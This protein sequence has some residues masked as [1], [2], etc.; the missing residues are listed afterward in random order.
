VWTPALRDLADPASSWGYDFIDFCLVIGWPLD[1][2]QRWLAI[3]LGELFPD[4]SPRYRKAIVLVARQ[5][6]KT[7]FTRLLILYWMFVERV[8]EIVAT[9]TDRGAAKRSW[10]KVVQMAERNPELAPLLPYRHTALQIGG[11]AAATPSTG[12][13]W[14]SCAN[15]KPA[16]CGT[17]SCPPRTRSTMAWSCAFPTR[18]TR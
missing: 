16:T 11:P 8:P 5:N 12:P 9:S 3:H 15:T 1:A 2:W 4:G 18:E 6:G 10:R 14:T 17:R 13:C 7:I